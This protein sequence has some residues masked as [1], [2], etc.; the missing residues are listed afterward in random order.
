MRKI[1]LGLSLISVFLL[2]CTNQKGVQASNDDIQNIS[3]S[4]VSRAYADV[5]QFKD[6]KTGCEYIIVSGDSKVSI[7]PRYE[8]VGTS[9]TNR[10]RGCKTE[11]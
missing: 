6:S 3:N 9:K 1:L 7:T 2:G 11:Q 4:K 10:I 5:F 8:A